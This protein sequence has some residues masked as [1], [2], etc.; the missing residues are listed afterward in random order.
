[1]SEKDLFLTLRKCPVC[2]NHHAFLLAEMNYCGNNG[3]PLHY[4]IVRCQTCSMIYNNFSEPESVFNAYYQQCGK[5]ADENQVGGGGLSAEESLVWESYVKLL[6]P[7]LS[8]E[9]SILEV[10][11]GKGGLLKVL[12]QHG[13]HDLWAVE[14]SVSCVKNLCSGGINAFP[15]WEQLAGK[16]FDLIIAHAVLE[17]LPDPRQMMELFVSHL[18]DGG[19]LMLGVPDAD[20][21]YRYTNAPFYYFDREHINHFT[22]STLKKLCSIFSFVPQ[23]LQ[24]SENP[25]IGPVKFHRDI[26]GVFKRESAL[27]SVDEYIRKCS[28]KKVSVPP[29]IFNYDQVFLWGIG[30]YAENLL[31]SGVFDR[32][33]DL[34]LLDKNPAK[35][36]EVIGGKKVYPPEYLL[37]FNSKNTVVVITSVLYQDMIADELAVMGFVGKCI[38]LK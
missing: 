38:I 31:L 20:S 36:M 25:C 3:L 22:V 32:C 6:Q 30:A 14:P 5:Y 29:E 33:K 15:D 37:D 21:Y 4:D 7:F 17:H 35:Q 19:L 1:M 16:K 11:C 24:V 23:I 9:N 12:D 13:F 18:A 2:F 28:E 8:P 34:Y 10:G 27:S 26:I